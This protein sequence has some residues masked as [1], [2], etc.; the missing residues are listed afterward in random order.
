MEIDVIFKIAAVGIIV[1]IVC[2]IL[3]KSDRD[4]IATIVSLAGLIIVL[5]VVIDMVADLFDSVR[6]IFDL[7]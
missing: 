2:Q 7:F 3:K 4:D 1:T 5:A 6:N